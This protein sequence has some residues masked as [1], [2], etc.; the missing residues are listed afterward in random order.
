MYP[1]KQDTTQFYI[2]L[3]LKKETIKLFRFGLIDLMVMELHSQPQ[4][5]NPR[6]QHLSM[7]R[8]SLPKGPLDSMNVKNKIEYQ[9]IQWM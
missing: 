5:L 8:L 7:Y 1:T 6:S 4:K 3:D 9:N 2:Y